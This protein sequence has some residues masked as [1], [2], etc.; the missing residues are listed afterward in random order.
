[1]GEGFITRKGGGVNVNDATAFDVFYGYGTS[2]KEIFNH[3]QSGTYTVPSNVTKIMVEIWGGGGGSAATGSSL[4][5]FGGGAGGYSRKIITTNPGDTFS[6]TVGDRGEGGSGSCAANG[7]NGGQSSFSGTDANNNSINMTANGGLRHSSGGTGGTASGGDINMQ[8]QSR[9]GTKGGAAAFGGVGGGVGDFT[10]G[11]TPG[12]GAKG[13][14]TGGC[15]A[16]YNG[17][18]G[19]VIIREL[20][21][22]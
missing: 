3:P 9:D 2:F 10:N 22:F 5:D 16:G 1:M 6:F 4:A 14:G 11:E 12:G 19:S 18:Y 13:R 8:G 17:G 15:N 7:K 20:S 21:L